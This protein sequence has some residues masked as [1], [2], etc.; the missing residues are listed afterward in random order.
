MKK[1]NEKTDRAHILRGELEDHFRTFSFNLNNFDDKDQKSFLVK[2]WRNLSGNK[3][4]NDEK[5]TRSADELIASV[6]SSLTEKINLLIGAYF[7]N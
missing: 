5:L 7:R 3:D 2:Y 1:L 6:K 4:W